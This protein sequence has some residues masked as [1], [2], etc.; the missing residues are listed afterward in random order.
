MLLLLEVPVRFVDELNLVLLT[1]ISMKLIARVILEVTV[2]SYRSGFMTEFMGRMTMENRAYQG[3][4]SI[5]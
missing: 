3:L 4:A 2:V 1:V 5:R